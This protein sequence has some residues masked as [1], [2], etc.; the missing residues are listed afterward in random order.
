MTLK[1]AEKNVS[2]VLIQGISLKQKVVSV[3]PNSV[4]VLG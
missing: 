1:R 4:P 2:F 3:K